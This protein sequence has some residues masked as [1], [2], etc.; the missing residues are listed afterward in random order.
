VDLFS[1]LFYSE[2]DIPGETEAIL[3]VLDRGYAYFGEL[4]ACDLRRTPQHGNPTSEN[5]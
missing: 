5:Y 4:R 1:V 2:R 3:F